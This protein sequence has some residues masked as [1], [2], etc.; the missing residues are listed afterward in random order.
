MSASYASFDQILPA[1]SPSH[2]VSCQLARPSSSSASYPTS[3]GV[4]LSHLVTARD[5]TLQ[6]WEVRASKEGLGRPKLWHVRTKTLFGSITGLQRTKTIESEADSKDRLLVS[7]RDAKIALLEWDEASQDLA[8]V[9]VHT[10]ER[11]SQLSAGLPQNFRPALSLDPAYRCA[12]L[13]LP[14]DAIA[15]LPLMSS[16]DLDLLDQDDDFEELYGASSATQ[17]NG[18]ER[19]ILPY[20]PS[21]VLPLSEVDDGLRNIRDIVFLPNFQKPTAAF[22]CEPTSQSWTASLGTERDTVHLYLITLDLAATSHSILSHIS[23]LPYD[24]L[25]T[26]PSPSLGGVFV[27]TTT[28]IFHADQNGKLSGV[29]VN[30]WT[31]RI[32]TNEAILAMP[33]WKRADENR[34]LDLSNSH[35]IWTEGMPLPGESSEESVRPSPGSG[36]LL[37]QDGTVLSLRCSLDGRAVS[38]IHLDFVQSPPSL[39]GVRSSLATWIEA[40]QALDD[41]DAPLLFVGS[42]VGESK[43]LSIGGKA[44]Q[45]AEQNGSHQ[46]SFERSTNASKE[47]MEVDDDD[48]A[49]L[50]GESVLPTTSN[51]VSRTGAATSASVE[52]CLTCIDSLPGLGPIS[53]ISL[54]V[55]RDKNQGDVVKTVVAHGAGISAGLSQLET[56]LRPRK[57]QDLIY[58]GEQTN[59]L[60]VGDQ[61]VIFDAGVGEESLVCRI[62][63]QHGQMS[64]L[65]FVSGGILAAGKLASDET[66][67]AIVRES[68][69]EAFDLSK[70]DEG[71]IH[72]IEAP[73][74][75]LQATVEAHADGGAYY[76]TFTTADGVPHI[77]RWSRGRKLLTKLS[78]SRPGLDK[79]QATQVFRDVSGATDAAPTSAAQETSDG[80]HPAPLSAVPAADDEEVDYGEDDDEEMQNSLDVA[81]ISDDRLSPSAADGGSRRLAVITVTGS[82]EVYTLPSLEL[83]WRSNT[84]WDSP[85]TLEG[86]T[87]AES[88]LVCSQAIDPA[89]QAVWIGPLAD[90]LGVTMVGDDGLLTCWEAALLEPEASEGSAAS[91]GQR[92]IFV[93]TFAKQLEPSRESYMNP[94]DGEL[95]AQARISIVQR[96]RSDVDEGPALF[97]SGRQPGFISK[98]SKGGLCFLES[99]IEDI[100]SL[101]WL[102]DTRYV[103][104][105][106]GGISAAELPDD[107]NYDLALA[108][109]TFS[110]GR[111]YTHVRPYPAIRALVAAS[112]VE[113]PFALF[114]TEDNEIIR[115]LEADPTPAMSRRGAIELFKDDWSEPIDGFELEQNETVS[116][117][118]L[119]TLT[120]ASTATGLKEFIAVGTTIF[121]G[122]DRPTRGA[123]YIFDIVET[124]PN[125]DDPLA[126]ARLKLLLK[127]DARGPVTALS[128]ISGYLVCAMGQKLYIRAFEN[129]EVLIHI[130]FLDTNYLTTSIRRLGS[131]LLLSDLKKSLTF[132]GFQ[133]DPFK[134]TIFSRDFNDSYATTGNYL[135]SGDSLSFISTDVSGSVRLL[136]YN[137]N[138]PSTQG[139]QRLVLR[140]EFQTPTEYTA[141]T[142]LS[143]PTTTESGGLALSN[144]VL[145]GGLNGSLSLVKPVREEI[146]A[147]LNPLQSTMARHVQHLGGLNPRGFRI[148]R[149]EMASRPINKGVLDG[150]LLRRFIEGVGRP[151]MEEL[152]TLSKG[153][154][155]AASALDEGDGGEDASGKALVRVLSDLK[156][157]LQ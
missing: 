143:G 50:Y 101:V 141:S 32:T 57:Q 129:H 86:L 64:Q 83:L 82:L 45:E 150:A 53:D 44:K 30:G 140:T 47:K 29:R 93:K 38:T 70:L 76:I 157:V 88:I 154:G 147:R 107:L 128:D 85:M 7:F 87:S 69:L 123:T 18:Q 121:H 46:A 28:A 62:E 40:S 109:S 19:K 98:T 79:A 31:E 42:M 77:Y 155:G 127:E 148:V 97:I 145:L 66:T 126:N 71:P 92:L 144:Q 146:F 91:T 131:T 22:L 138:I 34:H 10:Y 48:D 59:V 35:L 4:V 63:D 132:V 75:I 136:D 125:L 106:L 133:E 43:V 8:T 100:N 15:V 72:F 151:K 108:R 110:T 130:A 99:S 124:V 112:S 84:L 39:A 41:V 137:P 33:E 23:N 122:E 61:T 20:T 21:F 81:D 51:E 13:L 111:E 113:A 24:T 149:N 55:V 152:L 89:Q 95:R 14:Q 78:L 135:I 26:Q 117:L 6:V 118:E 105:H 73:S 139:G 90:K 153:G 12:T 156:Q 54:A 134:L 37:L 68:T 102:S 58:G 1:T 119:L 120:S 49:D 103:A 96:P 116:A 65:G 16:S 104:S 2:A 3:R 27:V 94:P 74:T 67:F 80:A 114:D 17:G 52:Y 60:H 25:Y 36:L 56:R 5:E 11:A 115:S 142:T 9:S